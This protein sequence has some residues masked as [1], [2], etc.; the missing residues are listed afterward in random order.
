[1]KHFM[2]FNCRLDGNVYC[3]GHDN[4]AANCTCPSSRF[5]CVCEN[6][7]SPA[8]HASDKCIPLEHVCDGF[9][10]CPLGND[11][12]NCDCQPDKVR[13]G[14]IFDHDTCDGEGRCTY[15]Y[16][17]L[18][19]MDDC[20]DGSD[21]I[22]KTGVS[23][24][25]N[26]CGYRFSQCETEYLRDQALKFFRKLNVTANCWPL[27]IWNSKNSTTE[28]Q[29]RCVFSDLLH[30]PDHCLPTIAQ[31]NSLLMCD[32]GEL[33]KPREMCNYHRNC[34]NDMLGNTLGFRCK[35]KATYSCTREDLYVP[36]SNLYDSDINCS[37]NSDECFVDGKLKCFQCLDKRLIISTKQVCDGLIDCYDV[38]DECLCENQTLCENVRHNTNQICPNGNIFCSEEIGCLD[39]TNFTA[40]YNS[41]VQNYTTNAYRRKVRFEQILCPGT[42]FI[43]LMCDGVIECPGF[44]DECNCEEKH[45]ICDE[46]QSCWIQ[47]PNSVYSIRFCD[48]LPSQPY[49]YMQGFAEDYELD[50]IT[51]ETLPEY[52][53]EFIKDITSNPMNQNMTPCAFGYDEANCSSRHYCRQGESVSVDLSRTCDGVVDCDDL[54]DEEISLCESKRFYC[55]NKTPLSVDRRLVE[56]GIKDCTD[57]SDECPVNSNKSTIFSSQFEMIANPIIRA[58]FWIMGSAAI[59]GNLSVFCYTIK[60]LVT[61]KYKNR[62]QMSNDW[63]ILNLSAADFLMGV[64]LIT[65]SIKGVQ[66]SGSYCYNDLEWRTSKLC[67]TL[68]VFVILSTQT[69]LFV[70]C[71]MT[72]FRL[73]GVICPIK[74]RNVKFRFSAL[75]TAM[76]WITATVIAVVPVLDL[77]SGYF[78]TG[79]WYPNNFHKARVTSKSNMINLA[80]RIANR[81]PSNWPDTKRI[82][83][84]AFE[85]YKIQGETGYFS[86]TSV[87]MPRI[88]AKVYEY[89]WE[90]SLFLISLNFTMFMYI[91]VSYIFIYKKG[92][93]MKSKSTDN[94]RSMQSRI[95]R[96]ILTDFICWV[97]ICVMAYISLAGVN[98]NKIV[99]A[100]SAGIL[101]P[102]NSA[103]N[104]II[105]SKFVEDNIKK[106][107]QFVAR[108]CA[109][110]KENE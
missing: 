110:K 2:I 28:R 107:F 5:T 18:D 80:G 33:D 62:V 40:A 79:V 73:M 60:Q 24:H 55:V 50:E 37:D 94:A 72:T 43:G 96:L 66:F 68:G 109:R 3:T 34:P 63:F 89:T 64:Y 31:F 99:Y 75:S 71:I 76:A 56:D 42:N 8:C 61:T 98:L 41:C 20:E 14:C 88:F 57:G 105:Y 92:T 82:I 67:N 39:F 86:D 26:G 97:P 104:P 101:L 85:V 45:S 25:S 38:S 16:D 54:S 102:V 93:K 13:C 49:V 51:N 22:C 19:S 30:T 83:S 52:L 78:V 70:M 46:Q 95:S 74:L 21:E 11:E 4:D 84:E 65:I 17:V 87:C 100:V 9:T 10:D 7:T 6:D 36:Q 77:S 47:R 23:I 108:P 90:Y 59:V 69:S 91:L 58:A 12:D 53:Y 44:E 1:M 103:L 32:N 48:G 15:K 106:A 29:W 35:P 81:T 27:D